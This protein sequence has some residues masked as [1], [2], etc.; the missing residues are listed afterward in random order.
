MPQPVNSDPQ[1]VTC[2]DCGGV[3]SKHRLGAG[4]TIPTFECQ[5][6]HR[7][8]IFDAV[9]GKEHQLENTMWTLAGQLEH[10]M[11]LW[12]EL[13]GIGEQQQ[14]PDLSRTAARRHQQLAEQID[15]VRRL[16][17]ET[18]LR[19]DETQHQAKGKAC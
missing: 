8:S 1:L 2:P 18:D 9:E 10:L 17:Q 19:I 6:G 11:A 14:D 5:V 16:I 12:T 15:T 13:A 3:L 4:A 7:Y